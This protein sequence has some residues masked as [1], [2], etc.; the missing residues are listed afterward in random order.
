M[1]R[2]PLCYLIVTG[3]LPHELKLYGD[4]V[5]LNVFIHA[6]TDLK[7]ARHTGLVEVSTTAC[8]ALLANLG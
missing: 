4:D 6:R 7:H 3:Y 5:E 1:Y 2:F 8:A